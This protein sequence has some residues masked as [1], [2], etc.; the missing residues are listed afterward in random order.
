MQPSARF[1]GLQNKCQPQAYTV[2]SSLQFLFQ[3]M[4]FLFV[5][6]I[7]SPAFFNP[8]KAVFFLL[9]SHN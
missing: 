2:F 1:Q 7:F 9:L 8:N 6:K 4:E 5:F 3:P